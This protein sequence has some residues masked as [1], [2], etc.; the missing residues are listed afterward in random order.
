MSKLFNE[1]YHK[2][3]AIY[4]FSTQITSLGMGFVIVSHDS[5]AESQCHHTPVE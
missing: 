3:M 4:E 5:E 2:E 1:K